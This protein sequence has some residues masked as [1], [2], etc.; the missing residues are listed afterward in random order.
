VVTV[1]RDVLSGCGA[2]VAV[3]AAVCVVL[4]LGVGLLGPVSAIVLLV[5][6]DRAFDRF[7]EARRE[8]Q[9]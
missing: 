1:L 9:Q 7:H 3:R 4:L 8:C 5:A 6:V 2:R